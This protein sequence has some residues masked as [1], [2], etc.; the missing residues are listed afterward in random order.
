MIEENRIKNKKGETPMFKKISIISVFVVMVFA[1]GCAN[2]YVRKLEVYEMQLAQGREEA[3]I[4]AFEMTRQ[5][6][7]DVEDQFGKRALEDDLLIS[8]YVRETKITPDEIKKLKA[9]SY[10]EVLALVEQRRGDTA[11]RKGEINQGYDNFFRV[12]EEQD[13]KLKAAREAVEKAK[14]VRQETYK[15]VGET[16]AIGAGAVAIA[17]K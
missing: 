3:F 16:L 13:N 8:A 4:K 14:E 11:K 17:P 7:L 6:R 2:P 12:V 1:L 10:E 5:E 15:K 9:F